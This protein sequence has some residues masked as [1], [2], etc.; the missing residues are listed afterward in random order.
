MNIKKTVQ[1]ELK[2]RKAYKVLSSYGVSNLAID[3][4][5]SEL[6]KEV[7]KLENPYP[8]DIFRWDNKEK[9]NFNRGRFNRHCFEIVENMRK[10]VLRILKKTKEMI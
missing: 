6:T 10:D 2:K 8:K 1:D 4:A 3:L 5:I 9:L 7:E